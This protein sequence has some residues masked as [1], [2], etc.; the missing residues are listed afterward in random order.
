MDEYGVISLLDEL[1]DIIENAKP[2]L[3]NQQRRQ[4]EVGPVFDIIDEI[5]ERFPDEFR[6]ARIIVKDRQGMLESAEMEARRIV[7]DA[8][9]QAKTIASEQEIVRLANQRAE[10][11]LR[12]AA[13]RERDMKFGAMDYADQIFQGL[14][15]TLN[16]LS[17]NVDRCRERLNGTGG[18]NSSDDMR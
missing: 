15:E 1:S 2:V 13:E 16:K 8:R 17:N 18:P 10:D 12:D 14:Q 11:I 6:E 7:E 9:E 5:R 4:V 3:G